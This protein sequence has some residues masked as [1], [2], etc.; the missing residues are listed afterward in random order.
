MYMWLYVIGRE[1]VHVICSSYISTSIR[2]K[3]TVHAPRGIVTNL[4]DVSTGK[5][6]TITHLLLRFILDSEAVI[7]VWASS[8]RVYSCRFINLVTVK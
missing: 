2:N 5:G 8:L 1:E 6:S 4:I 3:S 7:E